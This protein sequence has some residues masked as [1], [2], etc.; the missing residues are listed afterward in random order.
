MA[1][2]GDRTV[3][4]LEQSHVQLHEG[5]RADDGQMETSLQGAEQPLKSRLG[6]R[7]PEL[8]HLQSYHDHSGDN[9]AHTTKRVWK[10][11]WH[12]LEYQKNSLEE[13]RVTPLKRFL[14]HGEDTCKGQTEEAFPRITTPF[15][16][17]HGFFR[18]NPPQ[19]C[20][21]WLKNGEEIVQ[22]IVYGDILPS[23][24]G[25][26]GTWVSAELDARRGDLHSTHADCGLR[27]VFQVPQ[28][29]K[30]GRVRPAP[31]VVAPFKSLLR[32]TN[33]RMAQAPLLGLRLAALGAR[34]RAVRPRNGWRPVAIGGRGAYIRRRE[35]GLPSVSDR[36]WD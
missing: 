16:R 22:E 4:P 35:A 17:V 25:T 10:A 14:E 20:M 18:A 24:D 30:P 15:C 13:E 26:Y 2:Q 31:L 33:V 19:I 32:G 1:N 29:H 23:G 6:C 7:G 12:E 21:I 8:E 9:M 28:E 34:G 36:T 5:R 3:M 27:M 11:C